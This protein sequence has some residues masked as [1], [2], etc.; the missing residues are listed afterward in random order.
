M[1]HATGTEGL[2]VFGI[3]VLGDWNATQCGNLTP[4]KDKSCARYN[5]IDASKG[6][7]KQTKTDAW[8]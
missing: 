2:P 4:A 5:D 3:S 6:R 1:S 7:H 8:S